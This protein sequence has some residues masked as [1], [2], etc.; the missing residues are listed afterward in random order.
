M[1]AIIYPVG[2][3]VSFK[4][5]YG[6]RWIGEVI[7]I[8]LLDDNTPV[9]IRRDRDGGVIRTDC[10]GPEWRFN[11]PRDEA[12]RERILDEALVG[13]LANPR[14]TQTRSP[15]RILGRSWRR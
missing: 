1:N 15:R 13:L 11:D 2:T 6:D 7:D 8:N 9:R 14:A 12:E 10:N 5:P 3:I 4:P